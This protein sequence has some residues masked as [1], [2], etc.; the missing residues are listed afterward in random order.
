MHKC[1]FIK[2]SHGRHVTVSEYSVNRGCGLTPSEL[3]FLVT[4]SSGSKG[5]LKVSIPDGNTLY[6]PEKDKLI[7][8][9]SD[10]NV[11]TLVDEALSA[12]GLSCTDEGT[13][14]YVQQSRY[15]A[16]LGMALV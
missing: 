2:D 1:K 13:F 12:I 11:R 8:V 4:T 14:V 16:Y 3:R 7:T 5:V 15:T 9:D 6:D 10:W